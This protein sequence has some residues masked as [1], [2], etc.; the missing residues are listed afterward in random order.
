MADS[1]LHAVPSAAP[2]EEADWRRFYDAHW[3]WVHR[4]VRRMGG[5]EIHVEDAVQDV[6][7]VVIDRIVGFEGRAKIETWLYRICLN[8][9]SEHRRRA[10]RHRRLYGA[11]EKIAFWRVDPERRIEARDELSLVHR[12]LNEMPE[13]KR[14]VLVL[15]EIEEL[16][17]VEIG[18]VLRV[19]AATVR[20]RLFYAKKE[21]LQRLA[22]ERKKER[23][24]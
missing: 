19:P 23:S 20:T 14:E 12:I 22:D 18:E 6:F 5:G 8:V 15:A 10:R 13:K 11:L 21:F 24:E 2:A 7:V 17:S 4:V 3:S 9:V 1:V 16:S